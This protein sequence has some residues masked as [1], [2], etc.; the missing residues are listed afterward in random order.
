MKNYIKRFPKSFDE[1]QPGVR[2]ALHSFEEGTSCLIVARE[3]TENKDKGSACFFTLK[4]WSEGVDNF[5]IPFDKWLV[6]DE[7]GNTDNSG[8]MIVE[9]L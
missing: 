2:I 5:E 3:D 9:Y 6:E 8:I 7:N 1:L 4:P